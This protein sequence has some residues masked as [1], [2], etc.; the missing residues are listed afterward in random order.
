MVLMEKLGL[1]KDE[2][3]TIDWDMTPADTFGIYESWGTKERIRSMNER[4]Y[5][6]YI[7]GWHTPAKLYLMERGIRF[8]RILAQIDAPRD[9]IESCM[10]NQGQ[11]MQRNEANGL[12]TKPSNVRT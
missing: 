11:G 7:D 3:L 4:C 6:F 10:A 8:A 2:P 5:Y 12:F 9:L 1:K